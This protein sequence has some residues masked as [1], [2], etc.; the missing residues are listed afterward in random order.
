MVQYSKVTINGVIVKDDSGTDPKKIFRWVYEKEEDEP[1]CDVELLAIRTIYDLVNISPGQVVEIYASEDDI[2]Y[3]R[4]FYGKVD[5]V[6]PDGAIYTIRCRNEMYE[7]VKQ[8]VNKV[9]DASVDPSAGE[10]S[11]IADDL[12]SV[13]AGLTTSVQSS[14][15]LQIIDEFKCINTDIYERVKAI[16]EA[17]DWALYYKDETRTAHFEPRGFVSSGVTLTNPTNV[18]GIPKWEFDDSFMINDLRVD[19][20]TIETTITESGQIGV[21]SG[22]TTTSILLTKTP[23]SVEVLVDASNPPTT[24][25][26]G[27]SKDA[28]ATND[29]WIDRENKKIIPTTPFTPNHYAVNNYIWSSPAPIH[30][31][32]QESIDNYGLFE[33]TVELSDITSVADAESRAIAILNKRSIPFITGTLLVKSNVDIE[34][35]Q[36]VNV[37]DTITQD[38][39]N[40]EYMINK[41]T[42]TYPSAVH[43][44]EVGDKTWRM[45]DWQEN[46]ESRLKRLEEQ[47][48]RNQDIILE[49]LNIQNTTATGIKNPTPRYRK[50][51][52]T[53]LNGDG[54]VLGHPLY[55]ILGT[56]KLGPDTATPEEIRVL[57]YEDKYSEDFHDT[58]FESSNTTAIWGEP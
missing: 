15:L 57:Q 13:Q 52:Q 48:V 28:S 11:A 8:N 30:M 1:I 10:L 4:L 5:T 27:G 7:L 39:V 19:G 42:Y 43:E 9:Y 22:Y 16:K 18:V 24:Q 35:G 26:E 46:T 53:T 29:Y 47:F 45:A 2:T 49:L 25:L 50:V 21:T 51:L 44:V 37:V 6:I 32:N 36:L 58:D 33:K 31:I 20:A 56:S 34:I 41:I 23:N 55:D 14:G 40:G 12:M 17:L 38:N 54:F 3:T